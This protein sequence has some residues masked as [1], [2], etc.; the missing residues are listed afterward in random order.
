MYFCIFLEIAELDWQQNNHH[1]I[2][3]HL[4][5]TDLI[6][7]ADIIY[8]SSLF[9]DLL[10]TVRSLFQRCKKISEFL[11]MNAVRNIDTEKEFLGLLGRLDEKIEDEAK[12]PFSSMRNEKDPNVSYIL[13][14]SR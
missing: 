9:R 3:T 8:D 5:E 10:T 7:G 11:L 13:F 2:E 4:A 6:I 14:P 1:F 12:F